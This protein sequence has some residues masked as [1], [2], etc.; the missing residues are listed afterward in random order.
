MSFE[1][2][3][4]AL[5]FFGVLTSNQASDLSEQSARS[6]YERSDLELESIDEWT[7]RD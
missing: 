1:L 7:S 2:I 6:L 5:L 3:I 4:A